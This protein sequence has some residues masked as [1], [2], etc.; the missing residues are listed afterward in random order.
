MW[1]ATYICM[2]LPDCFYCKTVRE[3]G[4]SRQS[5]DLLPEAW[6]APSSFSF[7]RLCHPHPHPDPSLIQLLESPIPTTT[8][9]PTKSQKA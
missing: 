8:T 3:Y 5:A 2:P 9:T 1:V 4:G 6:E 7:P